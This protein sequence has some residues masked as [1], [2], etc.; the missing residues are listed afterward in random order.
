MPQAGRVRP[1]ADHEARPRAPDL[2]RARLTGLGHPGRR[3]RPGGQRGPWASVLL[4]ERDDV[5]PASGTVGRPEAHRAARRRRRGDRVA[6]VLADLR[7]RDALALDRLDLPADELLEQ[8]CRL[9]TSLPAG[10]VLRAPGTPERWMSPEPAYLLCAHVVPH[11]VA[12]RQAI[13]GWT[14]TSAL[15]RAVRRPLAT[16]RSE[17]R[18]PA[19]H[20]VRSGDRRSQGRRGVGPAAARPGIR[21]GRPVAARASVARS[22]RRAASG[23]R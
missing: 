1:P 15:V 21:G 16:H 9:R 19:P 18:S 6:N 7:E 5:A 20:R 3:V 13:K 12:A 10:A 2:R 8:K 17:D 11:E 22:L 23:R 4:D 14:L